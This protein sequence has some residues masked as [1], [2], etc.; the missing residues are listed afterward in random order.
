MMHDRPP[1]EN[2]K[3][4]RG[5]GAFRPGWRA[6]G[7][8]PVPGQPTEVPAKPAHALWEAESGISQALMDDVVTVFADLMRANEMVI[9]HVAPPRDA[10]HERP[11]IGLGGPADPLRPVVTK[12]RLKLREQPEDEGDLQIPCTAAQLS[13]GNTVGLGGRENIRVG[14][15][16]GQYVAE[17]KPT[18]IELIADTAEHVEC[19]LLV[20]VQLMRS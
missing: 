7:H 5:R 2:G 9:V 18:S 13:V 19:S 20:H 16:I 10:V 11:H 3:R 17:G 14:I 12:D 4:L 6:D 15:Q 8:S 1:G